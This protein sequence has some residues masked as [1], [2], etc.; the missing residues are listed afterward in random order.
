MERKRGLSKIQKM[1]IAL[2]W[3]TL[4]VILF[5]VPNGKSLGENIFYAIASGIII[6][7]G[8]SAGQNKFDKDRNK[9]R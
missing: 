5:T 9:R 2:L 3:V 4:C 7:V 6:V 8:V 1:C